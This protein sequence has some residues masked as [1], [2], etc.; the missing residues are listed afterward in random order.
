MNDQK[1]IM[2]ITAVVDKNNSDELPS[3]LE[4]IQPIFSSNG[5]KPIG[6]YK[7]VQNI[8]G[9]NSPE[10]ISIFEFNNAEAINAMVESEEFI[11]LGEL[12]ERVFSKMNLLICEL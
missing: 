1:A 10:I 12:R 11:A 3:Y 9:T 8:Q 6:R 4:Q 5:A 7:T 2:V